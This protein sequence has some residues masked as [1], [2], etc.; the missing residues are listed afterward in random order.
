MQSFKAEKFLIEMERNN[1]ILDLNSQLREDS[2]SSESLA[3]GKM[4]G[5]KAISQQ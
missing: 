2:E 4:A 5:T 3:G 1:I